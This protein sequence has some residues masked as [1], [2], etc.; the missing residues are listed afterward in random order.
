MSPASARLE[1][2]DAVTAPPIPLPSILHSS[3]D[4]L[5]LT[6]D[7][8]T[9]PSAIDRPARAATPPSTAHF[10]RM[11][12]PARLQLDDS[13]NYRPHNRVR[14]SRPGRPKHVRLKLRP[15]KGV[16]I[17]AAA[18]EV[19]QLPHDR[20]GAIGPSFFNQD[21]DTDPETAAETATEAMDTIEET[22][23]AIIEG[24]GLLGDSSDFFDTLQ[25]VGEILVAI[26]N[27]VAGLLSVSPKARLPPTTQPTPVKPDIKW[28]LAEA[29]D[30][31]RAPFRGVLD[32]YYYPIVSY[33][34]FSA[35]T[36]ILVQ[37]QESIA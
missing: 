21:D 8:M 14:G 15:L 13:Y 3:I 2:R 20:R 36:R 22:T 32:K 31:C 28:Y 25:T 10:P 6:S 18:A 35:A 4:T 33:D 30:D 34:K 17:L 27:I 1:Y 11:F 9:S 23:D 29:Q 19:H 26:L 37:Q 7:E 24:L 5:L 16:D 12:F